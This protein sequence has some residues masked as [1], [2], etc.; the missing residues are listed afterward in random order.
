MAAPPRHNAGRLRPP[1][2]RFTPLLAALEIA[3]PQNCAIAFASVLL[4]GWL[5]IHILSPPLLLAALTAALITGGG[6]VHNDLCD[7]ETDRIN[8]PDRPLPSGRLPIRAARAEAFGLFAAGVG[9]SLLLPL[10]SLA[11]ALVATAG[12]A[13]YNTHLKRVPLAGNL[14]VGLLGG[15]AFIYGGTSAG[16]PGPASVPAFFAAIFHFG[17]E[18]I[19]DVED[20]AGDRLLR[21]GTRPT[22]GEETEAPEWR[23]RSD[24]DEIGH[25]AL[26][27]SPKRVE[28]HDS[29][30]SV[31]GSDVRRMAGLPVVLL[32]GVE[33]RGGR[34]R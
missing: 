3:R 17:R 26:V 30:G 20:R 34:F 4:G 33:P 19:K 12:L 23:P 32:H 28:Q 13:L 8:R 27:T 14:L 22:T 6:N 5:G 16:A 1:F 24:N 21:G 7:I 9:F 11:I 29:E 25:Q 18:L 15:L 2:H 31:T 10:S